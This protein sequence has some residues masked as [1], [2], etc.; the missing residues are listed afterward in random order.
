M[1]FDKEYLYKT[2]FGMTEEEIS[3]M[4][5]RVSEEAEKDAALAQQG[6]PMA[7]GPVPAPAGGEVPPEGESMGGDVLDD[8]SDSREATGATKT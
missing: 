6:A 4:K 5:D 3:D 7:G 1:L 8:F 2:Y